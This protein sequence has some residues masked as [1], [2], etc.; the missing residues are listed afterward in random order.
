MLAGV[1]LNIGVP[2]MIL[3]DAG[4]NASNIQLQV[5]P[6]FNQGVVVQNVTTALQAALS[7]PNTSFG[8]LLQVS[9]LYSAVTSVPG[10]AWAVIPVMTREDV[11]QANTNPIQFRQSE[12][13]TAGNVYI[14]ASG[15]II[16]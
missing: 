4:S 13:P 9:T 14:T 7:P 10:V 6:N 15:G 3:V 2:A 16:T 5:L 8:E 1:S 11:T 12:I